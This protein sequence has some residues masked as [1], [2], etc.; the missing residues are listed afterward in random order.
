ME[1]RSKSKNLKNKRV[2][3]ALLADTNDTSKTNQSPLQGK[4]KGLVV[5]RKTVEQLVNNVDDTSLEGEEE[6]H[7][8]LALVAAKVARIK[9]NAKKEL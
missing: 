6:K 1:P 9:A 5:A 7:L 2:A 8:K 4:G 3:R